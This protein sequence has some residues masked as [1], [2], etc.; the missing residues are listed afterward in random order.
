MTIKI[1]A[2][3]CTYNRAKYLR[4]SIQSL[5]DQSLESAN[6]EII[7]VDNHSTDD[8]KQIVLE[9][10]GN[11]HNLKYLY[12]PIQGLSQ[13]RNTGW[14]AA[15]ADYVAYLDDDAIASHQW[16]EKILEVFDQQ[17]SQVGALGGKVEPIWESPRPDWLSDKVAL[18]LSILDWTDQ[19]LS[20]GDGQWLVGANVA[21]PKYILKEFG[22]FNTSLG[23]KGKNLLSCEESYL[24]DSIIT[25]GYNLLYYP[26]ISVKHH[27]P[28]NRLV[29]KWFLER[30]YWNGI[31]CAVV[32][33][34]KTKK[35]FSRRI[36]EFLLGIRKVGLARLDRL[37]YRPSA[38]TESLKFEQKCDDAFTIGFALQVLFQ[39]IK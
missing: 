4:K 20:L 14:Q 17:G 2:I 12:E 22:G 30:T 31:S 29:K 3:I 28:A 35:V 9:E 18:S 33:H 39:I 27:I 16:L 25:S 5:I 36:K 1:S 32:E 21:Y 10:F 13:A 15:Q 11:V 26:E 23:R 38:Y 34:Y 7:V 19:P 8:T 24:H 6:Y 37:Q